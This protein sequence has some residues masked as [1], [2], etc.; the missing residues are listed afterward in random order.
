M[1]NIPILESADASKSCEKTLHWEIF[2]ILA[3]ALTAEHYWTE[4]LMLLPESTLSILHRAML[5][6]VTDFGWIDGLQLHI[7]PLRDIVART[8]D[9]V[10]APLSCIY[11]RADSAIKGREFRAYHGEERVFVAGQTRRTGQGG[12]YAVTRFSPLRHVSILWRRPIPF[13]FGVG[14]GITSIYPLR[15]P[16]KYVPPIVLDHPA[17]RPNRLLLAS[18]LQL[19][20]PFYAPPERPHLLIRLPSKPAWRHAHLWKVLQ[21]RCSPAGS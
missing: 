15:N 7:F 14:G 11:W 20:S 6:G 1:D 9:V 21:R 19:S 13:R 12:K 18:P 8:D 16:F 2:V 4:I 3:V 17:E 5:E 10:S